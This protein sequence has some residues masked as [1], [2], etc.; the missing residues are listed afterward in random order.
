M[1][2]PE[3]YQEKGEKAKQGEQKEEEI[4]AIVEANKGNIIQEAMEDKGT[5]KETRLKAS[6]KEGFEQVMCKGN[7]LRGRKTKSQIKVFFR[8]N[9]LVT[10]KGRKL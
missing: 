9:K 5:K 8:G 3:L 7:H 4:E 1:L 2:H 6:T 10:T